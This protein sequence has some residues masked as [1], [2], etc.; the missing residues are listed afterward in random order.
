MARQRGLEPA[1]EEVRTYHMD[2]G[3]IYREIEQLIGTVDSQISD[4]DFQLNAGAA[5]RLRNQI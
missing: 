2:L 4:L 5:Q 1:D 3:R